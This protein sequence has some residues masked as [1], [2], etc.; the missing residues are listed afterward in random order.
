MHVVLYEPDIPGNTGNVGRSCVATGSTLHLVGKLGFS[1]DDT[2]VRRS[3]LDYWEKVKLVKHKD[4]DAFL[5]SLSAPA[6]LFF[7]SKKA[8]RPFW[9][10]TFVPESYLI[11]GCETSGLPSL[12]QKRYENQ[13][14]RIPMVPNSVRS[15]NLSTSVG[16]VLYE[17]LRQT[18]VD[19]DADL[20]TKTA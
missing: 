5:Q 16:V 8:T 2:H 6:P 9:A 4:W 14:Y 18:R 20:L 13:M 12:F 3:G 7:F 15:L 17:A 19:F 10:A 1:L 11:F